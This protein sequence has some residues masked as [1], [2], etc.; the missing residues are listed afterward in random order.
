MTEDGK[1][2]AKYTQPPPGDVPPPESGSGD[3]SVFY[4]YTNPN[5]EN[6]WQEKWLMT[7]LVKSEDLGKDGQPG[8]IDTTH[9]TEKLKRVLGDDINF[10]HWNPD[11][12]DIGI[13]DLDGRKSITTSAKFGDKQQEG[14][15]ISVKFFYK[16]PVKGNARESMVYQEVVS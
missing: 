1:T 14:S 3:I 6:A 15:Q 9:A 2:F 12:N 8:K 10:K 5:K 13:E 11:P 4:K 7:Q 16:D